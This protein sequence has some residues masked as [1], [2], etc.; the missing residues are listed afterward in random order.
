MSPS[1]PTVFGAGLIALDLVVSADPEAPVRAWAGGTCG[2]VLSILAYLGWDSYPVARLNGDAASEH[3]RADMA[4]WGVHLDYAS[5][6]PTAHTP[7]IIQEIRRDRHGRPRHRFSWSC[8]HCGQ[9]LPGF[10]PVTARAVEMVSP[11]LS[12]ASAF[13]LDRLS[14]ATID[15]A[16]E[17]ADRGAVVV[18]EP[19]GKATE[20]LMAEAVSTAHIVKYSDERLAGVQGLMSKESAT[21]VEVQTHGEDGLRY[22][23]RLGGST[24]RWTRLPAIPAPRLADTCGSGDW[25]TAGIMAMVATGGAEGMRSSTPSA[26]KEALRYGQALAAWNCGFEGARGGM[27]SVTTTE[28]QQQ[29]E[30]LFQGAPGDFPEAPARTGEGS[31][32][33]CPACPRQEMSGELR[34]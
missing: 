24:P 18:F 4:R 17:A 6:T 19:S 3:V 16:R 8:P 1:K 7:I 5:C 26:L 34:H 27:Y 29:I 10:K 23:H 28:F 12:S 25:C 33:T 21:L 20:K 15:L 22:R 2:N 14:R 30:R 32:V 13:F 31:F 9:W 11:A